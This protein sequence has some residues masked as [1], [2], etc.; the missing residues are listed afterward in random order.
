M[1]YYPHLY[2]QIIKSPYQENRHNLN[3]LTGYASST[4]VHHLLYTF[5]NLNL[6]VIL[7]MVKEQP[8]TIWDHN[9]YIN[10]IQS[11]NR[12]RMRYFNGTPPIHAKVLL[13]SKNRTAEEVA[14]AGSANLTW[15]GFRDYQE[16]MVPAE[17]SFVKGLFPSSN[18]LKDCTD[19]DIFQ[20]FN[21]QFQLEP[22]V[23]DIDTSAVGAAVRGK[24]SVV[25]PLTQKRDQQVHGR[26]GLNWGQRDGREP[27]QAYIP[28]PMEIHR[29]QPDFFPDRAVDFTMIT[30]D[31]ESFICTVAQDGNK[32]IETHHD[33]S[34]MGKYFR[35]R[36]GVPLGN[37]VETEDLERY[38]RSTITIYKMNDDTF[39]LDFSSRRR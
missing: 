39:Y 3:V 36:I 12:L 22:E 7:G 31:G 4:F 21:M 11:T 33:N 5:E 34:I 20:F 27:N 6:D 14:F 30:D 10:L 15:H 28:I 26:S 38:G 9:E 29:Q 1:P 17:V 32:A 37:K 18:E 13:W 16:I 19:P 8:I 25:L 23:S 24:P 35:Q 2:D